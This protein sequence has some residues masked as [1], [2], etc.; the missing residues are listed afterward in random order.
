MNLDEFEELKDK[1]D[2]QM[3]DVQERQ[4][5][6]INAGQAEDQDELL[7]ELD[8][9]EA[10]M[11]EEEFN[12]MEVGVGAVKGGEQ[13]EP[14]AVNKAPQKSKQEDDADMLAQMMA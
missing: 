4:D 13:Q 7:D 8:Q 9:L 5:F 3:A 12:Q 14:I 10:E 2:D 6:F 1:I 11:A